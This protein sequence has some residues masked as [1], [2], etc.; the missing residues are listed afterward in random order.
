ME[1]SDALELFDTL[2]EKPTKSAPKNDDLLS[3]D[4]SSAP[5][6]PS[7]DKQVG[8]YNVNHEKDCNE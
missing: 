7:I 5:A 6:Q 3:I 8:I 2:K 4:F 1:T